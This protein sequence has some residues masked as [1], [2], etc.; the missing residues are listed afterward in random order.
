MRIALK[1]G[2]ALCVYGGKV[3]RGTQACP[4]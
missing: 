4:T 3:P 1:D 2:K